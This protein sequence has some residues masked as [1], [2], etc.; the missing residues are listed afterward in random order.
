MG[1]AQF[2]LYLLRST[3]HCH[4]RRELQF[5]LNIH[6]LHL[7]FH[8]GCTNV[9]LHRVLFRHRQNELYI[10]LNQD[11]PFLQYLLPKEMGMSFEWLEVPNLSCRLIQC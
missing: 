8:N 2:L 1:F 5:L 9:L 4:F 11:Q 6:L 7:Q 10:D 3:C